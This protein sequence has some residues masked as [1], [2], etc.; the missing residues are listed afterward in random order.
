MI[1]FGLSVLGVFVEMSDD[2][3]D[4]WL[5]LYFLYLFQVFEIVLTELM[6]SRREVRFRVEFCE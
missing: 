1:E 2:V 4:Q 5:V 3:G 6:Q